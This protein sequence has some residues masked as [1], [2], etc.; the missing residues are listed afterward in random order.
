MV[1]IMVYFNSNTD[2][3]LPNQ[4]CF[5]DSSNIN[6]VIK[7]VLNFLFFF[8]KKISQVQKSTKPLPANKIKNVYKKHLSTNTNEVL[9][10][11]YFLNQFCIDNL[12]FKPV[13]LN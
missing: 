8:Y 4:R 6:E 7:S 5:S 11:I 10:T 9:K 12:D 2:D 13:R 3:E 1:N